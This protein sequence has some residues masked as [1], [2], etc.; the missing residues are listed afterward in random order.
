[1]SKG[2][3]T[4]ERFNVVLSATRYGDIADIVFVDTV[5]L[6]EKTWS[7]DWAKRLKALRLT[8][9]DGFIALCDEAWNHIREEAD[10]E[11]LQDDQ[12]GQGDEP[13]TD[14]GDEDD[15]SEGQSG[16]QS[17]PGIDEDED[18]ADEGESGESEGDD[19]GDGASDESEDGEGDEGDASGESESGSEGG[20]EGDESDGTTDSG[21]SM[22][23]ASESDAQ[24]EGEG[25]EP[26]D[27]NAEKDAS[28]D[29]HASGE[30][31]GVDGKGGGGNAEAK[32][33]PRSE[34]DFAQSEVDQSMHEQSE[35][36]PYDYSARKAEQAVRTY[37]NTTVTSFGVHGS[38][39]TEW[40]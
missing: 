1:M 35:K 20:S 28:D 13:D 21:E 38:L 15:E 39:P 9:N 37:A 19:E 18:E 8:D 17:Q 7:R 33:P 6:A 10:E 24:G 2:M 23:G 16:D 25:G 26:T 36:D 30:S 3:T 22:D 14:E 4:A 32:A 34:D 5:T 31:G 27:A 12:S 11:P 40:S 29:D